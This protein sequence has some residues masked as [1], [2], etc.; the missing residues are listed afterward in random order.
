MSKATERPWNASEHINKIEHQWWEE[1]AQMVS[2]V[3]EMSDEVSLTIRGGYLQRAQ[4]FFLDGR[5]SAN[6]LELG[7]GSGWVGQFLANERLRIIGTDFSEEQI[8]LSRKNALRRGVS[9]YCTYAVQDDKGLPTQIKD[10]NGVLLHCFMH[11]LDGSEI[12]SLLGRLSKAS[13]PGTRYFVHEPAF[14]LAKPPIPAQEQSHTGV[15]LETAN[16]LHENLVRSL[17][18]NKFLNMDIKT[19]FEALMKTAEQNNWYLTPKEIPFG[20]VEFTNQ[21]ARYFK[22]KTHYWSNIYTIGWAFDLNLITEPS[23]KKVVQEGILPILAAID[24]VISR[25]EGYLQR[26]MVPPGYA[27]HVWECEVQMADRMQ[28]KYLVTGGLGFIGNELVRQLKNSNASVTIFD[29]ASRCAPYIEDLSSVRLIKGSILDREAVAEVFKEINPT[30]V[31]HLAAMHYI[32]E[33]NAFP[34]ECMEINV[35]GTMRV[36]EAAQKA[37]VKQFLFASSGAVYADSS[38]P[39]KESDVVAP[40]DIYGLSKYAAEEGLRLAH[41]SGAMQII[42]ARLFNNYG[43][44]ETNAHIIPEVLMQLKKSRKLSLGNI[45]TK[46][47]FISTFDCA[48]ALIDLGEANLEPFEILNVAT[49]AEYSMRELIRFIEDIQAKPIQIELDVARYRKADKQNQVADITL[50]KKA[51]GWAPSPS[52]RDGLVKLLE[53]EDSHP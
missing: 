52:L 13:P 26:A 34:T 11:H 48:K 46:R 31:I 10:A 30:T 27:F 29:N 18:A 5:P 44:R 43:P 25:D 12:E 36:A 3:W 8:L 49:G 41:A 33:C 53:F 50:L 19:R 42:I 17:V 16:Q 28:K 32:P 40:I 23:V 39:L 51:L 47:D 45:D 7:C 37:G 20:I 35:V 4:Q 15:Y 38:S 1:N 24:N 6:V 2:D 21:L 22:V 9:N 14:Y